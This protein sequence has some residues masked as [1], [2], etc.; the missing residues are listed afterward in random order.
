MAA[1]RRLSLERSFYWAASYV[2]LGQAALARGEPAQAEAHFRA[3][4]AT[5]GC[6]AWDAGQATA[7]LAQLHA[8][9][10]ADRRAQPRD[11]R[12]EHGG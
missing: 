11:P 5:S 6:S 8:A 1:L 4:L 3:A 2:G 10:R 7:G 9:A 12:S